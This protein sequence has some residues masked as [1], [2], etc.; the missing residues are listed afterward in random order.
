[1]VDACETCLSKLHIFPQRVAASADFFY[2]LNF[3]CVCAKRTLSINGAVPLASR[4]PIP[5]H[6]YEEALDVVSF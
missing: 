1:M 2:F 6:T 4:P 3:V 5:Y